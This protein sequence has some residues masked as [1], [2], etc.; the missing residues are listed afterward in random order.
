MHLGDT[1]FSVVRW[2]LYLASADSTAVKFG[3]VQRRLASRPPRRPR[4]TRQLSSTGRTPCESE[5]LRE[6]PKRTGVPARWVFFP[7]RFLLAGPRRTSPGSTKDKA[8]MRE[9]PCHRPSRSGDDTPACRS[10]GRPGEP[11]PG[12]LGLLAG[13]LGVSS[14]AWTRRCGSR[15]HGVAGRRRRSG[16]RSATGV[17]IAWALDDRDGRER[18][19]Y[20]RLVA[21]QLVDSD[22]V[23]I[24]SM[25]DGGGIS[26]LPLGCCWPKSDRLSPGWLGEEREHGCHPL[27]AD[28]LDGFGLPGTFLA[29]GESP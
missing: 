28:R 12:F 5:S 15:Q 9:R 11:G 16:L 22:I 19:L 7:S 3:S 25:S 23:V 2:S 18:T 17:R 21:G 20:L 14:A 13:R 10:R 27:R 29:L 24:R 8:L 4:T 1:H 6:C 26:P